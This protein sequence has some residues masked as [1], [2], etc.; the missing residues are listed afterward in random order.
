M[1]QC[2]RAARGAGLV[3]S[4]RGLDGIQR[5]SH[6]GIADGVDVQCEARLVHPPRVFHDG[7][8]FVLQTAGRDGA[9]RGR[10]DGAAL[11]RL[12]VL[13]LPIEGRAAALI[14]AEHWLQIRCQ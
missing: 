14:F 10:G 12:R 13:V 3:V 4:A 8:A 1:G 5:S 7:R 11:R 2:V 9:L 6:G